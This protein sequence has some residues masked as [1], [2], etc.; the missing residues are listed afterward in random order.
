MAEAVEKFFPWM[1]DAR[2]NGN[3]RIVS[4]RTAAR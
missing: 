1:P 3:G 2:F 4:K